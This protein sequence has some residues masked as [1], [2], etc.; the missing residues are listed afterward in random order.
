MRS[1][2]LTSCAAPSQFP[3]PGPVEFAFIGRSN[4][5][6]STLLNG[7]CGARIARVSNT[8]GRTQLV[9]FF[10]LDDG[11]RQ[12][13]F[14]D[15]PGYGYARAPSAVRDGFE[16]L[17]DGYLGAGRARAGL[18]LLDA[19]RSPDETDG[20]AIAYLIERGV[21]PWLVV[22]KMDK[23]PKAK[24]KPVLQGLK[25]ALGVETLWPTS[26][27]KREGLEELREALFSSA[28]PG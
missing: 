10:E 16:R 2:F 21:E 23:L 18:V 5:G 14:V 12:L 24:K 4:V 1:R 27:L 22:T 8:P 9:N 7:L 6:K 19:R 28:L 3:E 15:L 17:V 20:E 26:S 11:A 25:A 13:R